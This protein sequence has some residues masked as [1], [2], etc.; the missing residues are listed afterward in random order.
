[1]NIIDLPNFKLR[2]SLTDSDVINE[3]IW[4]FDEII[5]QYKHVPSIQLTDFKKDLEETLIKILIL[6]EGFVGDL[7]KPG[8]TSYLYLYILEN[9]SRENYMKE[10]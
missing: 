5:I 3:L 10:P 2:M 8:N 4:I 9:L 1:M 7:R 6:F